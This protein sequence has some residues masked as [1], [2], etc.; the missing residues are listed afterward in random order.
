MLVKIRLHDI[1]KDKIKTEKVSEKGITERQLPEGSTV[2]DLVISL[3]LK[4]EL[5]GLIIVNGRQ[6]NY[7]FKLCEEDRVELFSPLSGG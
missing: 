1:L 7:Q 4:H 3:G 2:N 5:V 6:V